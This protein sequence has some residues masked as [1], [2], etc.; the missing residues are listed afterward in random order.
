MKILITGRHFE[1]TPA[2]REHVCQKVEKAK[3]FFPTLNRVHAILCVEKFRH[4][5]EVVMSGNGVKVSGAATSKNMYTS[6]DQV[7]EK[8]KRQVKESHK[9]KVTMKS[10]HRF[11][12]SLP[13]GSSAESG[14]TSLELRLDSK[15]VI[16]R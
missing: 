5:A 13:G 11:S 7:M 10:R 3:E 8:I 9:K 16:A 1:I 2:L 15:P 14:L 6:I 12:V 4:N